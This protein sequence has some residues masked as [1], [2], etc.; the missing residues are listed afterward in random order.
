MYVGI[1]VESNII[2]GSRKFMF[3]CFISDIDFNMSVDY[4]CWFVFIVYDLIKIFYII[5]IIFGV[6][7]VIYGRK[8]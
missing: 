8:E 3:L 4:M 6:F 2:Q 7:L 1:K 5:I